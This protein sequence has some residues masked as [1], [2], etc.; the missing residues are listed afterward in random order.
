MG[1]LGAE[2]THKNPLGELVLVTISGANI[3][4]GGAEISHLKD[5]I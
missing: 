5:L 4:G 3:K 2:T 1:D